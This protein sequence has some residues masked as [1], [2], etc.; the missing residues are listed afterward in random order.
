MRGTGQPLSLAAMLIHRE[1]REREAQYR[2]AKDQQKPELASRKQMASSSLFGI[3]QRR[4]KHATPISILIREKS[5]RQTTKQSQCKCKVKRKPYIGGKKL[6]Q[7]SKF[8]KFHLPRRPGTNE[9]QW[10]AI[11]HNIIQCLDFLT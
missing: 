3:T 11:R 4:E 1:V 9:L 7:F 5:I 10:C 6:Y 8:L 2:T